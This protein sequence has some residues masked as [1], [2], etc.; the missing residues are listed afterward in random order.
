V[1]VKLLRKNM[2]ISFL[3]EF[4]VK[5]KLESGDLVRLDVPDIQVQLCRQLLC[6]KGK[7][8]T[9]AMQAMI[10]LLCEEE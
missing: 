5:E 6:H 2:G 8:I 9:P 10:D 4:V 1:I 7:W 3:P